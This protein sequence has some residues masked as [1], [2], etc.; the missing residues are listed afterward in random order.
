MF[1]PTPFSITGVSVA[2]AAAHNTAHLGHGR[3]LVDFSG[4]WYY[5]PACSWCPS[6]PASSSVSPP[7]LGQALVRY[8]DT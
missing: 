3:V 1:Y 6:P 2:G 7:R 8:G 5:L 4:L